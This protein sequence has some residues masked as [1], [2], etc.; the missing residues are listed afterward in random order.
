M[1][2]KD[3]KDSNWWTEVGVRM[4]RTIAETALSMITVGQAVLDVNWYNVLSVS[5]TSGIITMLVAIAFGLSG[6]GKEK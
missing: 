1:T 5:L 4:L 3:L 2:E 6:T